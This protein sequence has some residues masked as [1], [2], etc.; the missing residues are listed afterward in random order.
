[1]SFQSILTA[2]KD[3]P[4]SN[5]Q[6]APWNVP[7]TISPSQQLPSPSAPRQVSPSQLVLSVT[8]TD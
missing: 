4:S 7:A 2:S 6:H 3:G 1:M 5:G 8:T